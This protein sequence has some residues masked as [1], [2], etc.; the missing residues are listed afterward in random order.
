MPRPDRPQ[1]LSANTGNY[2]NTLNCLLGHLKFAA[3][4]VVIATAASAAFLQ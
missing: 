2:E 3:V 1:H 4:V